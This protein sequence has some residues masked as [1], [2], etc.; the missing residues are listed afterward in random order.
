MIT[1]GIFLLHD[2]SKWKERLPAS[3]RVKPL[4]LLLN[5]MINCFPI[6]S[7]QRAFTRQKYYLHSSVKNFKLKSLATLHNLRHKETNIWLKVGHRKVN[8]KL[9]YK[10]VI[11]EDY[12]HLTM[13]CGMRFT[14]PKVLIKVLHCQHLVNIKIIIYAIITF[15]TLLT[16]SDLLRTWLSNYTKTLQRRKMVSCSCP[17][18]RRSQVSKKVSYRRGSL[19]SSRAADWDTNRAVGAHLT[20]AG[21]CFPALEAIPPRPVTSSCTYRSIG[22]LFAQA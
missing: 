17:I 1:L 16:C 10:W 6:R 21:F 8:V 7:S 18:Y 15:Q 3:I 11:S 4:P 13:S 22:G 14:L 2:R 20:S 9:K 19:S 5:T 12:L